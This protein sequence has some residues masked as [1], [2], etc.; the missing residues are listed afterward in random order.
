MARSAIRKDATTS[1]SAT[2]A[3]DGVH[4]L[5]DMKVHEVSIVDAA[6]NRRR[7]L[8][9]K[10]GETTVDRA[11]V[12][13]KMKALTA[14]GERLPGAELDAAD[15]AAKAAPAVVAPAVVAPAVAA[16]AGDVVPIPPPASAVSAAPVDPL[17]ALDALNKSLEVDVVPQLDGSTA[18]V[19]TE[20]APV[21]T[22]TAPAEVQ[23]K[24]KIAVMGGI[25]AIIARLQ[26]LSASIAASPGTWSDA[27]IPQELY[28]LWYIRDMISALYDIGGPSWEIEVA[29]DAAIEAASTPVEMAKASAH[30]AITAARVGKLMATHRAL[31]YCASDLGTL[32]KE[33]NGVVPA[34]VAAVVEAPTSKSAGTVEP[35][36]AVAID[37]F[38]DPRFIALTKAQEESTAIIARL[39]AMVSEQAETITKARNSIASSNGDDNNIRQPATKSDKV[40]WARDLAAPKTF[41]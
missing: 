36:P 8:V 22:S 25:D 27:G 21:P 34:A 41:R 40:V 26:T 16:K 14:A 19:V 30:K 13:E 4:E 20:T 6:A 10:K 3:A 15:V 29:A 5:T 11:A 28:G 39:Q 1:V 9:T 23:D 7:F 38:S 12:A 37:I 18:I 35:A 33:L 17:A 24:I 32:L 31:K 2:K